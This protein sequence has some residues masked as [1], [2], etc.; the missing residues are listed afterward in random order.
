M[1]TH[2]YTSFVELLHMLWI[3]FVV[4]IRNLIE[5]VRVVFLYYRHSRFRNVDISF[6]LAYLFHNPY[7]I[8]KKFLAHKGEKDLYAYGETPLTTMGII[9]KE[10]GITKED[11]LFELGCG[12]GRGCFWLNTWVGCNVVGIDYI[13]EFIEKAKVLVEKNKLSG[14]EFRLED[15]LRTDYSG[16]T[17]LYLYGTCY[18]EPFIKKLIE[19][20]KHLPNGTRIISVSYPLTDYDTRNRFKIVKQ[21][22]GSFTWGET[23]IYLQ[24]INT[25][26]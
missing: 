13:P 15:I 10:C 24:E 14:I 18:D 11:T 17:V 16:A 5:Y 23:D 2:I 25:P 7:R 4:K 19:K 21:F 3:S 1:T 20:M 12:R 22:E 6:L 26:Q 8:S 9:I